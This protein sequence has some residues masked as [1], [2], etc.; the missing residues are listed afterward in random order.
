[1]VTNAMADAENPTELIA[2][3]GR[4]ARAAARTPQQHRQ[5]PPD[6]ALEMED[7]V[8]DLMADRADRSMDVR[9]LPA[10]M[11][12]RPDQARPAIEA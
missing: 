6:L 3:M 10:G 5:R 12:M 9:R 8:G 1:M 2:D 11:A 7:A 4:R